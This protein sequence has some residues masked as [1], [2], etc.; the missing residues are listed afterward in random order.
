MI[1]IHRMDNMKLWDKIKKAFKPDLDDL[2][3]KI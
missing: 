2:E 1:Y 3:N